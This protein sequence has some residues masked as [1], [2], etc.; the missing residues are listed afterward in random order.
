MRYWCQLASLMHQT[1]GPFRNY[2][3]ADCMRLS[4]FALKRMTLPS[5]F[6][7]V[8]SRFTSVGAVLFHVTEKQNQ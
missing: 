7:V 3:L 1:K 5:V 8:V 6:G 2:I 4:M